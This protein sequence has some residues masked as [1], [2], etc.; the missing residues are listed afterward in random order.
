MRI[1]LEVLKTVWIQTAH[2]VQSNLDL[3][4]TPVIF[5][6]QIQAFPTD[7][8]QHDTKKSVSTQ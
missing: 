5:L 1:C 7:E 3:Y 6:A 2:S 4:Y 8:I